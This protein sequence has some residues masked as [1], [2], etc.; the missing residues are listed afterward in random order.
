MKLI[1][2]LLSVST[3]ATCLECQ[4]WDGYDYDSSTYIEIEKGNLVREGLEIEFYD[5]SKGYSTGTIES[6]SRSGSSVEI[7][8]TDEQTGE[9]RIFEMD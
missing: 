4:A 8:V 5:Y 7:E 1:K 9:S 2:I 6:I 3:I